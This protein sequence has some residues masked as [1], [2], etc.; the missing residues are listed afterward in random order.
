M[1]TCRLS[2]CY[3]EEYTPV[4]YAH[5]DVRQYIQ[6]E[7]GGVKH[8]RLD[9]RICLSLFVVFIVRMC[10]NIRYIELMYTNIEIDVQ[11]YKPIQCSYGKNMSDK[12]SDR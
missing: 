1:V 4:D 12:V 10:L 7:G 9:F 11:N 2:Y 6:I 3:P 5:E 8:F